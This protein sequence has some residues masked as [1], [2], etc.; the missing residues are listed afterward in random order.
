MIKKFTISCSFGGTM[1]DTD[2]YIGKPGMGKHPIGFQMKWLSDVKGGAVPNDVANAIAK[3]R[4]IAE[5]ND[6]SFEDLCFYAINIANG[7]ID[8]EIPEFNRLLALLG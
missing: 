1:T 3:I 7:K 2:F 6:A 5:E 4:D 8:E